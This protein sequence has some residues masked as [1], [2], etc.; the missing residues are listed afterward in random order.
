LCLMTVI[1]VFW[2]GG[3]VDL[4]WIL[5][6]S[7]HLS[8]LRARRR[9]NRVSSPGRNSYCCLLHRVRDGAMYCK[10]PAVIASQ[11]TG[12]PTDTATRA[13]VFTAWCFTL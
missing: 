6:G 3:G 7:C 9:L 8:W 13:Y 1:C 11:E 2:C 4:V 12:S 5:C 10:L